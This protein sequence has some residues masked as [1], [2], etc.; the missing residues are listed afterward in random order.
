MDY[1]LISAI[2]IIIINAHVHKNALALTNVRS[3]SFFT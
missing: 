2:F 3:F 1:E